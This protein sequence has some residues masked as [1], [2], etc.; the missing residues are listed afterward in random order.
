[1]QRYLVAINYDSPHDRLAAEVRALALGGDAQFH[2]VVPAVSRGSAHSEG[3]ER[4]LARQLLDSIES[5]LAD[6]AAVDGDLGDA[7]LFAAIADELDR[8]PYDVLII[9][10]PPIGEHEQARLVDHLVRR[11]GLPVIPVTVTE[12][13]WL[14][15]HPLEF[16]VELDAGTAGKT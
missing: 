9:A 12:S 10:T 5:A 16:G 6:V 11:Y 2:I 1:M 8:R 7:N 13:E 4:A 15:H 3:Q 14:Q